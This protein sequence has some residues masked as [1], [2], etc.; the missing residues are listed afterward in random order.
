M[1]CF[2]CGK[3]NS[4]AAL[5]SLAYS[6]FPYLSIELREISLVNVL[7]FILSV[8]GLALLFRKKVSAFL[9]VS[10]ATVLA[11]IIYVIGFETM[12]STTSFLIVLG[13]YLA[14]AAAGLLIATIVMVF[15][16]A[17]NLREGTVTG[18]GNHG[19]DIRP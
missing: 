12:W 7:I 1:F 11:D 9:A 6:H 10:A 13:F 5:P 15:L 14:I 17:R 8:A 19:T 2:K 18:N 4:A 3:E 16:H